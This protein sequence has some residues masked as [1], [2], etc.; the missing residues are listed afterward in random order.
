M[1]LIDINVLLDVV[2][3]REPHYRTSAAVLD[4]VIRRRVNGALPAHAV[5]TVYFLVSRY[6]NRRK[7]S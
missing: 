3:R 5:T 2:Q 6:Q 7:A 4:C 1:I